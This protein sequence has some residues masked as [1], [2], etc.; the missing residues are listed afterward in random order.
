MNQLAAVASL[1]DEISSTIVNPILALLFAGGLLVF[2]WGIVEFLIALNADDSEKQNKG[3]Q[4]MFWGLVGMFIM[5]SAWAVLG[6][7]ASVA[8]TSGGPSSCTSI[9]N[10]SL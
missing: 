6:V 5:A 3:K 4:H 2:V 7:I 9:T 1:I 8:C 10:T